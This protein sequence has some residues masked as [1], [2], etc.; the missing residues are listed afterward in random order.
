MTVHGLFILQCSNYLFLIM[1]PS[2]EQSPPEPAFVARQ[3]RRNSCATFPRCSTGPSMAW[4]LTAAPLRRR[5]PAVRSS[6]STGFGTN[7]GALKMFAYRR[8]DQLPRASALVRRPARLRPV[9][10]RLRFRHR[11]V[12]ARQALW[13]CAADG[14]SSKAPITPTP[15]STGSIQAMSRA[16]A[17]KPL[18]FAR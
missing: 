2:Q 18:R 8:L 11:L 14:R 9:R 1:L 3:E 5:G 15:A 17:A 12:D 4:Q 13:L 10:G 7:P 16:V 6:K